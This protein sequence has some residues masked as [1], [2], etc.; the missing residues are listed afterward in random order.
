MLG[1]ASDIT[2][3]SIIFIP[4]IPEVCKN[5]QYGY[6][7]LMSDYSE[8]APTEISRKGLENEIKRLMREEGLTESEA[9]RVAASTIDGAGDNPLGT[10]ESV[11]TC[12]DITGRPVRGVTGR[13]SATERTDTFSRTAEKRRTEAEAGI[14][15]AEEWLRKNDP[16]YGKHKKK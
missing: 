11:Q 5:L 14:D 15:E 12:M 3:Y 6:N 9:M 8:F 10:V 13:D 2:V 1:D 4:K 16:E 7:G